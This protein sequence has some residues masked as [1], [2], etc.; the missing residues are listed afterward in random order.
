[1]AKDV[2]QQGGSYE[3]E[4]QKI[5]LPRQIT[6]D[7]TNQRLLLHDGV[8]QGGHIIRSAD[9][10]DQV[11]QARSP[12]LVGMSDFGEVERGFLARIGDALYAI[13]KFVNGGGLTITNADGVAGN[14][15][16]SLA[17][18]IPGDH[19]FGGLI[20]F[21]EVVQGLGFIGDT[22]GDHT[23]NVLGNVTGNSAGTH[24]GPSVG[25]H[26]GAVDARGAAVQLD[27]DSIG[28]AKVAGLSE[29]LA[30]LSVIPTGGIIMWAGVATDV[31]AGW[32]L[33]DGGNGTPDLRDRFI[34]CAGQEYDAHSTGGTV[35]YTPAGTV[36]AGGTHSH[37]GTV[38]GH[39]LTLDQMPAHKHANG[40]TD[41]NNSLFNHGGVGAQPITNDS[42]DG[43]GSNGVYEGWT[44]TVGGVAGV[45]Q[46]HGHG[47][48]INEG[49]QH[50]H[51]FA[52]TAATIRPPFYA[53]CLI[54]KGPPA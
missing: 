32:F 54:M 7:E 34:I 43:N 6:V 40:V 10:S 49:G 44:T 19:V 35:D 33:C 48:T 24:T 36:A 11:Y 29:A 5:G 22:Q 26:T 53:L 9:E 41:K 20:I 52:G 15:T 17:E 28:M 38:N 37:N 27:D 13:R 3:V 14:V 25:L 39:T 31:P 51:A 16:L 23:G 4:S 46:P 21:D 50:T 18:T 47:L 12:E 42:I 2:Q 8:T 1:M 30:G 45:T